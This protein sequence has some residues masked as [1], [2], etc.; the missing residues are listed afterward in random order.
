MVA[1]LLLDA[2]DARS[3]HLP[4]ALRGREAVPIFPQHPLNKQKAG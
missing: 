2:L 4:A 1:D 3:P